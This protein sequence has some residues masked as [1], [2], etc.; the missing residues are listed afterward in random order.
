MKS[1][2]LLLSELPL[3]AFQTFLG[4]QAGRWATLPVTP[5][6]QADTAEMSQPG[7][8]TSSDRSPGPP[9]LLNTPPA[10]LSDWEGNCSWPPSVPWGQQADE[11]AMHGGRGCH[12]HT[13]RGCHEGRQT[14]AMSDHP[15]ARLGGWSA[16]SCADRGWWSLKGNWWAV[17]GTWE[18]CCCSSPGCLERSKVDGWPMNFDPGIW[19]ADTWAKVPSYWW[20]RKLVNLQ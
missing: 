18:T 5:Q 16:D 8:S 12:S 1:S 3:T 15:G 11:A 14:G 13:P 17:R 19:G 6:T 10:V 9:P 4:R 20:K 7:C 2:P